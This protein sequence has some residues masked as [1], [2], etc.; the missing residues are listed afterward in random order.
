MANL[1]G[2]LDPINPLSSSDSGGKPND[3]FTVPSSPSGNNNGLPSSG[4]EPEVTARIKRHLIHWFVPEMGIVK[5]YVNPN[6]IVYNNK[7]NISSQRTKG[8]FTNQYW[9]EELG[10][11]AIAGTT[12]SAGIEGIN[13]LYELYRAEQ[14]G[15]DAVGL[16]LA[17]QNSSANLQTP[18]ANISS[19][20]GSALGGFNGPFGGAGDVFSTLF[21]GIT[22]VD[23][24][25]NNISPKNFPNLAQLAFGVEM[26]YNGIVY[27]GYFTSFSYTE[28]ASDFTLNYNMD[29]TVLQ[30]RGYR[31]N[32][33]PWS[34]SA[35]SGGSN[36]DTIPHTFA[37][38]LKK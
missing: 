17:S 31:R 28:S 38:A 37:N 30:T 7:K 8:G 24:A 11:L 25:N 23:P 16:T 19:S 15:F 33:F 22:G 35:N 12:G 5:M 3:G 18:L 9:G 10:T 20:L 36:W 29:F 21:S 14:Y 32:Y 4:V 13:V 6:N 1:L 27:K 26:Y 34:Q 2:A